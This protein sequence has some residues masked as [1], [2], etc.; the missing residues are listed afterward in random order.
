[1][2]HVLLVTKACI[3][4]VF[5]STIAHAAPSRP[6]WGP[7]QPEDQ[8]WFHPNDEPYYPFA[9]FYEVNEHRIPS[10]YP[11]T[12]ANPSKVLHNSTAFDSLNIG[13][14]EEECRKWRSVEHFFHTM[15]MFGTPNFRHLYAEWQKLSPGEL[16]GEIRKIS[17][18]FVAYDQMKLYVMYAGVKAKFSQNQELRDLLCNTGDKWIVEHVE[19]NRNQPKGDSYWGDTNNTSPLVGNWL[20]K[21]LMVVRKELT[22]KGYTSLSASGTFID[23]MEEAEREIKKHQDKWTTSHPPFVD[24]Q[25][26]PLVLAEAKPVVLAEAKP[27]K[28]WLRRLFGL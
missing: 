16:F 10:R 13:V 15:K 8:V 27:E 25:K 3:V 1:M 9:N 5:I 17:Y 26:N 12:P 14:G 24:S 2:K 6:Q 19:P 7:G 28:S 4:G 23:A 22:G 20:G 21:V 11:E 18:D